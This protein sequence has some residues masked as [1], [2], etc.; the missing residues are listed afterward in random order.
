M[1]LPARV[2]LERRPL[3]TARLVIAPLDGDDARDFLRAVDASRTHLTP[4]LPWVESC[5]SSVDALA[6]CEAAAQDWDA[7]RA[8]RFGVRDAS[9]LQL[10]GV[11]A[12]EAV[13]PAH[14]NADLV[15][16]LHADALRHG[17]ATEAAAAVLTL[18]FRRAGM[19]RVRALAS[20]SN[21][22]AMGVLNK[23]G[24]R[25]EAVVRQAERREGR[26]V[27]ECQHSLLARDPFRGPWWSNR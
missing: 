20:P 12:L 14:D 22:G 19:H 2:E 18:A 16:W 9:T 1:H 27:D 13:V 17:F 15:G 6:R 21:L 25:F 5:A 26:W 8:L 24:F 3:T 11:V 7:A 10:I 4:W 23:L